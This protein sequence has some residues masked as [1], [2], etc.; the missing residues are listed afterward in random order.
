MDRVNGL[1]EA[2]DTGIVGGYGAGFLVCVDSDGCAMDTMDRKHKTCFGPLFIKL[3]GL[4]QWQEQ[5]LD[6]WNHIN[7]YSMSRGI[8]RFL[9]LGRALEEVQAGYCDVEDLDS[10][11]QWLSRAEKLSEA[12]LSEELS[13][14]ES[15]CLR[16]ALAWSKQVNEAIAA[17]RDEDKRP[18]AGVKEGLASA[19][20]FARLAVVSSANREAVTEEWRY[21]GLEEYVDV[22][23][24]QDMGSKA[25]CIHCLLEQGYDPDRVLMVG[26]APGDLEAA[27]K[28]GVHFFPILVG[29]ESES[30]MRL[31]KEGLMRFQ[32]G[33]YGEMEQEEIQKFLSNLQK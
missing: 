17:I 7:L 11:R 14:Q 8:N 4:E 16:R 6:L 19:K 22:M 15:P 10:L 13:R 12:G 3:W 32:D 20:R 18:F 2:A 24:T 9:A 28:N 21:W 5:L 27:R 1:C 29:K 25:A 23:L 33:M 26:D 30:W 31:Q